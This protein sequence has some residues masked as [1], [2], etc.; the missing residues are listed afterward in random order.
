M[1][2]LL[3]IFLSSS[4]IHA[5]GDDWKS[6]SHESETDNELSDWMSYVEGDKKITELTLMGTHDTMALY[7]GDIAQTQS[8]SLSEQL[9]AGIRVFDIRCRALEGDF[10]IHH[11][12]VY[13]N[14]KLDNVFDTMTDF[15]RD[16][17]SETLIVQM[18][19]EYSSVGDY[20]FSKIYNKYRIWYDSYI[21]KSNNK[22]PT[23]NE[24]RGKIVIMNRWYDGGLDYHVG[25]HWDIFV[26]AL[27]EYHLRDNWAL[28]DKYEHIKNRLSRLTVDPN[29]F[30]VTFLSGSGG[31]FP[32]F[33]VSGHSSPG[34]HD[35]ALLTGL[36]TPGWN[37]C[38]PD[39]PR[40]SCFIG[41]CSIIFYG[42][43]ILTYKYLLKHRP[44]FSGII[45]TDFPGDEFIS[46]IIHINF[47][48]ME[49]QFIIVGG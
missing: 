31:S 40:I 37:S 19:Q 23:L 29:K 13:Q 46:L 5:A 12:P 28:Y 47:S 18:K 16:H 30:K 17:P 6:Y 43:N 3:V 4:N 41:I 44:K 26:D 49:D 14:A 34:T 35:H 39:F 45:M 33:V 20:E 7:G 8:L 38:C 32:Y 11:G 25:L 2:I 24:V 9:K 15:L 36:T 48:D 22:I 10:F 1:S 42:T 21:W 27:D